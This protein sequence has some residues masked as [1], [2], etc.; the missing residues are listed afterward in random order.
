MKTM[1][2]YPGDFLFTEGDEANEIYFV[3]KGNFILYMDLSPVLSL[4][5]GTIQPVTQAFNV[6]YLSYGGQSFFGDSD[7][8]IEDN[9]ISSGNAKAYRDSTCLTEEMIS[10]LFVLKKKDLIGALEGFPK[11]LSYVISVAA[12]K[13]AYHNDLIQAIITRFR[14]SEK[15]KNA[16]IK[17]RMSGDQEHLTTFMSFKRQLKRKKQSGE[18][19]SVIQ[20]GLSIQHKL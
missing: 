5:Y 15:E 3:S 17:Y 11:M 18:E 10:Y 12:E 16:L 20:H 9:S 7:C 1:V 14:S 8:I 4:P 2:S 6:P 13:L 19:L